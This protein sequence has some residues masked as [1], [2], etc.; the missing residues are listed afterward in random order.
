L[1]GGGEKDPNAA[2][3]VANVTSRAEGELIAGFLRDKGIHAIVA[4]DDEAGLAPQLAA[5]RRVRV[6]VRGNDAARAEQL[7]E[8][9][10]SVSGS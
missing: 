3:A 7:I 1:F 6:L 9:N 5:M 8:D 2:I 4:A 10:D